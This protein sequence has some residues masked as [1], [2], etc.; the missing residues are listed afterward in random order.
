MLL[1][2]EALVLR[3]INIVN[4]KK[5]LVLFT[6][7]YGK[8][9]AYTSINLKTRSKA[10]LSLKPFTVSRFEIYKNGDIYNISYAETKQSYYT[11]GEDIDKYLASS[12]IL[13]LTDKVIV[14]GEKQ[15]EI[16]N[17]L[18]EFLQEISKR[19][20]EFKTLTIAYRVKVLD[21]LGYMPS[22]NYCAI[23]KSELKDCYISVREGNGICSECHSNIKTEDTASRLIFNANFDIVN[24]VKFFKN[25]PLLDLQ[26]LKLEE[27]NAEFLEMFLKKYYEYHLG[28]SN[29]KSSEIVF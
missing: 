19:K 25:R 17:L 22:I 15:L 23:C 7:K 27:K 18:K 8:I 26:K 28:I 14:E 21:L 3:Q 16:Y 5:V 20:N 11:I 24:I 2:T 13:E 29:L 12:V 4:G 1:E 9:S 10:A 6:E